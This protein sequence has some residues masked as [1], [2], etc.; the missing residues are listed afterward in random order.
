MHPSPSQHALQSMLSH[1]G[2]ILLEGLFQIV[3]EQSV[4][5]IILARFVEVG[6]HLFESAEEQ[7]LQ[8]GKG[9]DELL[10]ELL[11]G[12]CDDA[13]V[14]SDGRPHRLVQVVPLVVRAYEVVKCRKRIA[15]PMS[16]KDG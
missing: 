10:E 6:E 15:L 13:L 4:G 12:Q 8:I 7:R 16:L 2:C 14:D 3:L 9:R 1:I 11:A 5:A